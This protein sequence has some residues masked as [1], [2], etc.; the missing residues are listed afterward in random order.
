MS[1]RIGGHDQAL[2]ATPAVPQ[3]E[4]LQPP[5]HGMDRAGVEVRLQAH[6]EEP[7]RTREVAAPQPMAGIFGKSGIEDLANLVAAL[8]PAGEVEALVLV[9]VQQKAERAQPA[10][11]D[12]SIVG[13][14]ALAQQ[15]RGAS[16]HGVAL[17]GADDGAEDAVGMA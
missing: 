13:A 4:Q 6:R 14:G 9:M 11:A 8:E 17:G 15:D 16:N 3:P 10:Q 5:Q 1:A 12:V 2:V 7:G